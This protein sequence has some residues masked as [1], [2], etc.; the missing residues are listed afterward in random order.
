MLLAFEVHGVDVRQ[1]ILRDIEVRYSIIHEN[2]GL[3]CDCLLC[4][5]PPVCRGC[6]CGFGQVGRDYSY[7]G[8]KTKSIEF[9][10]NNPHRRVA[11]DSVL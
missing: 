3:V 6:F 4:N 10:V 8:T 1:S 9:K 11:Y 5:D 7:R 2:K